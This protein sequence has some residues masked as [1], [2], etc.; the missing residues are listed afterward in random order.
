MQERP[1]LRPLG[2]PVPQNDSQLVPCEKLPCPSFDLSK[3]E[4]TGF[5]VGACGYVVRANGS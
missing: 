4:M 1:I 3:I 5:Q 2:T